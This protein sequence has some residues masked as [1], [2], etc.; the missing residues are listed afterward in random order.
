[1][2]QPELA[3][4]TKRRPTPKP[5]SPLTSRVTRATTDLRAFATASLAE[6]ASRPASGARSE[7]AHFR[8][9]RPMRAGDLMCP[10]RR[11]DAIQ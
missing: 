9:V 3:A 6:A 1:M 4:T 10:R 11:V 7:H 5:D 8:G 2:R